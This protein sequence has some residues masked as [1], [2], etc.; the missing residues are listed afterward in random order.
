M[1]LFESHRSFY[2]EAKMSFLIFSNSSF[3]EQKYAKVNLIIYKSIVEESILVLYFK[4]LFRNEELQS[5]TIRPIYT[6]KTA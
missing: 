6:K 2:L 4:V 5:D 1:N 3:Q